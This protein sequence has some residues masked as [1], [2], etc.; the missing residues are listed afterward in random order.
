[1]VKPFRLGLTG[2]TGS[3][4]STAARAAVEWGAQVVDADQVARMVVQPGT[5]CLQEL[6]GEFGSDILLADGTLNRSLL[7]SRAFSSQERTEC[8]NAITHPWITREVER[9]IKILAG[10]GEMCIRDRFMT[11]THHYIMFFTN[12]GRVYRLKGYEIPEASRTARGTAIIN[13]LQLMPDEKITA[14]IPIDEYKE[15][16]YLFM[17]T[18]K[19]L[20]KKT[21]ITD[22]ANV[23]KTGL[24]AITLREE[25][26]LI[27]V[28]FTDQDQD[29]ILVTK[30]GQ[31]IR[32]N[33][34]DVRATGRTSMGVRGMNLADR[35]EVV[36]MQLHTQGTHLLIVS[37]KGMGKRTAMEEFTP[38][39]RGGK[40]VKCYK[41][42]EK[43]GNVV[44]V[45]AVNEDNE[46][47]IINTEGIVIR[48]ECSTISVL[49]RITSGV[50]LINLNDNATV[51]SI[52][53]V[54]ETE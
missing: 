22:Y 47:M 26:E 1:M 4:K 17:A 48:M 25:D 8:L 27:E 43:T 16:Q 21:P 29:I 14:M 36:G 51:A 15:G 2:P 49:G 23:R 34:K 13:L 20:V 38:Q 40:G 33:E 44:G 19:G 28:K 50:K 11:S 10:S 54:R 24:A 3:G 12:T 30:Y 41:I 37:E 5:P 42:T 6:A 31:C 32:F 46:V 45:K 53:K 39:N 9:Q 7:A 35:D 18:K 52:A